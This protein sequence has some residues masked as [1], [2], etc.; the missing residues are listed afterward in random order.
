MWQRP[1]DMRNRRPVYYVATKN[2]APAPSPDRVSWA[3]GACAGCE[4]CARRIGHGGGVLFCS[5]FCAAE[6]VDPSLWRA[7][8]GVPPLGLAPHRTGTHTG[9][10][11]AAGRAVLSASRVPSVQPVKAACTRQ[12][13]PAPRRHVRPGRPDGGRAR[14]DRAGVRGRGRAVL[15]APDVAGAR[16]VRRGHAPARQV[17]GRLPLRLRAAG[18]HPTLAHRRL[19][20]GSA[21]NPQGARRHARPPGRA[22]RCLQRG[23]AGWA[24]ARPARRQHTARAP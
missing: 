15:R 5:C 8:C 3:R 18:A 24:R 20:S 17:L 1:E 19:G 11:P 10:G 12:R 6:T 21:G 16:A 22:G 9:G 4:A 14:V 13:P 2:G 7:A 23:F